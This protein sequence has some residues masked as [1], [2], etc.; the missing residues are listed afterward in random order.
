MGNYLAIKP[1]KLSWHL[2]WLFA[3]ME[4]I[5][6][7]FLP[8]F[9]NA[10]DKAQITKSPALGFCLGYIGMLA[11]LLLVNAF[12]NSIL[13]NISTEGQIKIKRPF[14]CSFWGAVYLSLIFAFQMAFRTLPNMLFI[15][16]LKAIFS[17]SLSTLLT[18]LVYS[19]TRQRIPWLSITV[20]I[21]EDN[22]KFLG[23]SVLPA[24]IFI[25]LYEAMALPVIELFKK[26]QNYKWQ[27]GLFFGILAGA[28]ASAIV[29]LCY[30]YLSNRAPGFKVG[31]QLE[32]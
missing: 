5:T 13:K 31:I 12:S 18:L 27:A 10:S 15:T 21:G 30:N 24:V 3:F 22:Y 2:V 20:A 1:D 32:K 23:L 4:G 9:S 16:L 8:Y 17:M 29:I 19:T 7:L 14:I 6:V 26:F 25:S 11:V 28:F